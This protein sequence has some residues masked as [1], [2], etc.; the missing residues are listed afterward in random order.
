M[1]RALAIARD[2]ALTLA[3]LAWA[4]TLAINGVQALYLERLQLAGQ[5][6]VLTQQL[7]R[8]EAGKK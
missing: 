6:Q 5:V 4:A 2:V 7:Q 1:S 8:L 3:A